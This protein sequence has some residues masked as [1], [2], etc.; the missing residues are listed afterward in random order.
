MK[1]KYP[2]DWLGCC[3]VC[4]AMTCIV[5]TELGS[6]TYLY[7]YDRLTCTGC[8]HTGRVVVENDEAYAVWDSSGK[9]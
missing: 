8:G 4:G 5:E 2:I 1:Q 3:V 9:V 6:A 7:E